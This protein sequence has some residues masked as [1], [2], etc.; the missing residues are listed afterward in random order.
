MAKIIISGD[1][2]GCGAWT[3]DHTGYYNSHRGVEKFL[4]DNRYDVANVSV[5]GAA[6]KDTTV[7]L[8]NYVATHD[9]CKV[10]IW[11]QT[12]PLRNFSPYVGFDDRFTSYERLI[13]GQNEQLLADYNTLNSVG[14]PIICMGGCSK[15]SDM[16]AYPNLI[17]LIKS[18]PELLI[19]D[20]VHP[21]I[22]FSDWLYLISKKL[23]YHCLER[24]NASKMQQDRL[25]VE[26]KFFWPDGRHP[27]I[28]GWIKVYDHLIFSKLLD[29]LL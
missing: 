11:I 6:N 27:N 22:W 19:D 25:F 1:S 5:G 23:S 13:D 4:I 29:E 28:A 18:I 9:D 16:S 15:L 10:G 20:Y 8:R 24:M 21:D 3:D 7:N 2:W 26:K 17:P 14:I 12:D